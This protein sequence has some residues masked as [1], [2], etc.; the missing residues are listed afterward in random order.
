MQR[1][2][3]WLGEARVELAAARDLLQGGHWSWCCFTCQQAAEKALKALCERFRVSHFGH[4]L[5]QLLGDLEDHVAVP[6][7]MREACAALNRLYIPTRYP[8]AYDRGVP[9]QQYIEHDA[10]E[11]VRDAEE[12]VSFAERLIG[13][14]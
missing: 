4:N 11:A 1:D 12:V 3:D 10:H 8:D 2:Q 7:D 5:N 6:H 13:S 14:P 9:G